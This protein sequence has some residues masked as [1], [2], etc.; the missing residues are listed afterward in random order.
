MDWIN[1]R[2]KWPLID[3]DFSIGDGCKHEPSVPVLFTNGTKVFL[4]VYGETSDGGY[5]RATGEPYLS[6][7]ECTGWMYVPDPV[8]A[9]PESYQGFLS[10]YQEQIELRDQYLRTLLIEVPFLTQSEEEYF[11]EHVERDTGRRIMRVL[12]RDTF[13]RGVEVM[14]VILT[15]QFDTENRYKKKNKPS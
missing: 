9:V 1:P 10:E 14:M 13:K 15:S 4:G 8:P 6:L 11:H 3:V 2:E 12:K 5:F 7:E